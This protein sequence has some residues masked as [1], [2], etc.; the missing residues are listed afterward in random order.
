MMAAAAVE[1]NLA[2]DGKFCGNIQVVGKYEAVKHLL[3]KILVRTK[4]LVILHR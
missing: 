2:Y 3:F 1:N 4:Y